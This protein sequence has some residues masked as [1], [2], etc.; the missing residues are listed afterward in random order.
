MIRLKAMLNRFHSVW[1]NGDSDPWYDLYT[2]GKARPGSGRLGVT[3]RTYKHQP[4]KPTGNGKRGEVRGTPHRR[5]LRR[6][7]E[8]DVKAAE[9]GI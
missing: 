4:E 8:S 3:F 2:S 6:I 9:F 1:G 5:I 7:L